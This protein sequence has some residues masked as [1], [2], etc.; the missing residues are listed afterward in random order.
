VLSRHGYRV[1]AAA[2][3]GQALQRAQMLDGSLH[4][5]LT[6]VVLPGISGPALAVHLLARHPGMKTLF[7]SGYSHFNA[8]NRENLP[9]EARLLQK[10]FTKNALLRQVTEIL[11]PAGIETPA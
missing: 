2:N 3:S 5:L 4:L 6:D 10:P 7:M 9:P 11:S 1:I 8:Q